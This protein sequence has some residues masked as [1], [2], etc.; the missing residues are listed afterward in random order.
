MTAVDLTPIMLE[1]R[2]VRLEPLARNHRDGLVAA[3]ADGEL[4]RIPV[5]TVPSP[6]MMA[7]HIDSALVE[8]DEG[9]EMPFV[10]IHV[11]RDRIVGSTRYMHITPDH[12]RVEI[13]STWLARTA[14]RTAVN[15]EAKFLLL[16]YAFE[17]WACNRIEFLTHVL[18]E[19]SRSALVR[20]GAREEGVLRQ[21]M[22]MPDGGL[23]DSICYS[24]IRPEWDAVKADLL[25]KLDD[26]STAVN[27]RSGP[28]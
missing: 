14:Q 4:W 8:Q 19:A 18:N 28:L 23:R 21:H 6:E 7:A 13:G 10:I 25:A 12:R 11:G 20:I 22:I 17:T 15:T 9:R 27:G 5:T 2:H 1:G 26:G 16:Q 3:A 24:I